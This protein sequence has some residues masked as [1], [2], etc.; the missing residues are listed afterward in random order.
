MGFE[1]RTREAEEKIRVLISKAT[2]FFS[3]R[4]FE[5]GEKRNLGRECRRKVS[6]NRRKFKLGGSCD[7]FS[8]IFW[9]IRLFGLSVPL[10]NITEYFSVYNITK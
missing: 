3:N 4:Q 10:I 9:R 8:I 5:H 7:M 6:N 1:R 2:F